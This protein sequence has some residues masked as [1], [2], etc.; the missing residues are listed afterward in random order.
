MGIVI[1][2]LVFGILIFV[3]E[4]GHFLTARIFGVG[5]LEF[6]IGMG[7]KL[8]SH[9]SKKSQ[10]VYSLRLLP[11]GGYV[12]MYGEDPQTEQA[13]D[14]IETPP[15]FPPEASF[16]NKKVWQRMII[17]VAGAVMNLL[18]GFLIMTVLITKQEL[19]ASTKIHS[20]QHENAIS[21]TCGLQAGDEVLSVNGHR[22]HIGT[23]LIYR[24]FLDGA[25]PMEFEVL[26][27]GNKETLMVTLP[28]DAAN[29]QVPKIDF[30]VS[31]TKE[32]SVGNIFK[33]SFYSSKSQVVL[34]VESIKGLFSGKYG[35]EAM[36]GPVGITGELSNAASTSD[37]G[38]SL[39][40]LIVLISI[41]LGIC[42]LLPIPALDG[43]RL[44]FL[45]IE[46]VRRKPLDP[47][48]EGYIHMIGFALLMLLFFVITFQDIKRLL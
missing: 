12:S 29:P 31:A 13:T 27:N 18:L 8:Y 5:I 11:I 4:L 44:L 34:V 21:Q 32:K 10:T 26:R 48:Y 15:D 16:S 42:N 9:K 25:E 20:F 47:K 22:V 46:G 33:H 23:E 43:G 3:H 2:L 40:S 30:F 41:N 38:E 19:Y 1:A 14:S 6:S 28:K 39:L 35:M 24:I 7:P 36:S 45:C 17:C 37:G